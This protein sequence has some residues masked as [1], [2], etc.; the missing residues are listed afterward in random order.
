MP[1]NI[2]PRDALICIRLHCS[3][4]LARSPLSFSCNPTCCLLPSPPQGVAETML[5][6]N[7]AADAD[8]EGAGANGGL[9]IASNPPRVQAPP[10]RPSGLK[11]FNLVQVIY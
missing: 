11:G 10:R 1:L 6:G 8:V 9:T 7:A 4:Y 3:I 2:R 5:S